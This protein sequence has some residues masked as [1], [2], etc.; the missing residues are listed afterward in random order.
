MSAVREIERQHAH[1][2][3][4]HVQFENQCLVQLFC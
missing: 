1:E 3:V 2:E 4:S